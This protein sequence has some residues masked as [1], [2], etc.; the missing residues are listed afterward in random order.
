MGLLWRSRRTRDT[1]ATPPPANK[2]KPKQW[3]GWLG[4]A[5]VPPLR[6]L[7]RVEAAL[8]LRPV[9]DIP[10]GV[11]VVRPAVLILQVVRVLPDIQT[12]H[13]ILALHHRAVLVSGGV[14]IELCSR[15]QQPRPAGAKAGRRRLVELFLE[16]LK[17]AKR[18]IDGLRHVA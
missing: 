10:P 15:F 12:H 18:A 16:R 2:P 1:R 14:D 7:A 6:S 5:S 9:H 4:A 11:D 8:D 3:A 17:S 13:R